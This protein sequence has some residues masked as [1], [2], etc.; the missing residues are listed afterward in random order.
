LAELRTAISDDADPEHVVEHAATLAVLDRHDRMGTGDHAEGWDRFAV[1]AIALIGKDG[2]GLKVAVMANMVALVELA[3]AADYVTSSDLV[4]RYGHR[5]I[6][7]IQTTIDGMLDTGPTMPM[8]TQTAIILGLTA[9]IATMLENTGTGRIAANEI[10]ERCHRT[11]FRLVMSDID[12][13]APGP[14]LTTSQEVAQLWDHGGIRAWRGQLAIISANPWSPGHV[15][16]NKLAMAADR[17]AAVAMLTEATTAYR[18][19]AERSER[20]EV[21][22][23]IRVLVAVSGLSQRGFAP[24]IGTSPSRL[25]TYVN[26]LVTPA[27]SMMIRMRRVSEIEEQRARDRGAARRVPIVGARSSPKKRGE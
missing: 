1:A 2:W 23:E 24:L 3:D 11:G 12:P 19:R 14:S 22:Q 5:L 13:G 16:V 6:A 7:A 17:P 20:E 25:S 18:D 21:A 26:G 10:A 15:E 9:T 27:A 8:A 4:E